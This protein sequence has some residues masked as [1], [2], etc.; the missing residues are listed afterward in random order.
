MF[1]VDYIYNFLQIKIYCKNKDRD[2]FIDCDQDNS[3]TLHILASGMNFKKRKRS[4]SISFMNSNEAML[5]SKEIENYTPD[6]EI[7]FYQKVKGKYNSKNYRKN[8]F[9][10]QKCG[11]IAKKFK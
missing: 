11:A 6:D 10:K 5:F 3:S 9:E 8:N 7:K 1:S 4:E 2:K